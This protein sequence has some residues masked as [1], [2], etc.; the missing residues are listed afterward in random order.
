MSYRIY[1]AER[2]SETFFLIPSLNKSKVRTNWIC[3]ACNLTTY[4]KINFKLIIKHINNDE[5]I[6]ICSSCF[7]SHVMDVIFKKDSQYVVHLVCNYLMERENE[8]E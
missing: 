6:H 2:N 1:Y 7:N 3:H 4:T 5:T 8:N